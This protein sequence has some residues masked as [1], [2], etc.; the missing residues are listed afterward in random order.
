[1]LTYT[2]SNGAI[3]FFVLADSDD[4][5]PSLEAVIDFGKREYDTFEQFADNACKMNEKKTSNGCYVDV[6]GPFKA[7]QNDASIMGTIFKTHQETISEKLMSN[8]VF[9]FDGGFRDCGELLEEK[10]FI[11]EMPEN[12]FIMQC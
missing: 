7:T 4:E 1:M 9:L 8:D 5:Q 2:T 11:V 12:D 3:K 10:N 6:I